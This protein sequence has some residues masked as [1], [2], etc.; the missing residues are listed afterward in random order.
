MLHLN[1]PNRDDGWRTK[2]VRKSKWMLINIFFPEFI[3]AKAV[4]DLRLALDDLRE[5]DDNL[6]NLKT[7][8]NDVNCYTRGT[9]LVHRWTWEVD[10]PSTYLY[11]LFLLPVPENTSNKGESWTSKICH[12]LRNLLPSS[13]KNP[14]QAGANHTLDLAV[15]AEAQILHPNTYYSTTR[16]WTLKHT[17]YAQ[18]GGILHPSKPLFEDDLEAKSRQPSGSDDEP[19]YQIL[20]ATKLTSRCYWEKNQPPP[21]DHLI[22]DKKDI[23]DKSKSDWL[24]I[25]I[26]I[27]Q[28]GWI[29]L[30]VLTRHV[31]GLPITQLEVA[32]VSFAF[33]AILTYIA[34]AGKPKNIS[35]PSIV[36]IFRNIDPDKYE[37][38]SRTKSFAL[39]LQCPVKAAARAKDVSKLPRISNDMVLMEGAVP[40]MVVI[41]VISSLCFGGLHCLAWNFKF[42]SYIELLFWRAACLV[43]AIL[44]TITFGVSLLMINAGATVQVQFLEK[45]NNRFLDKF[46]SKSHD[47]TKEGPFQDWWNLMQQ[48]MRYRSSE[49][50]RELVAAPTGSRNWSKRRSKGPVKK[51]R[52]SKSGQLAFKDCWKLFRELQEFEE[53][54]K[55]AQH[56]IQ[57]SKCGKGPTISTGSA[58]ELSWLWLKSAG[59]LRELAATCPGGVKFWKEHQEFIRESV[60]KDEDQKTETPTLPLDT[61]IEKIGQVYEEVT[62][63]NRPWFRRRKVFMWLSTGFNVCSIAIYTIARS[64]TLILLFTSLRQAPVEIYQITPWLRFLP[65]IG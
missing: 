12:R 33:L 6:R 40:P 8:K 64:I 55:Q 35:E 56:I 1:V 23:N 42:P 61:I 4:C 52:T 41:M 15:D 63:E 26:T 14:V 28:I 20:T 37:L 11:R 44:P 51:N 36:T 43:V 48:D 27:C 34:N 45:F 46:D 38:K 29:I 58:A 62:K 47:K 30:G 13:A 18:M 57:A 25:I 22:L 31:S 53:Y 21:L 39:W 54:W 17:Y 50:I 60:N 16:K 24:L 49:E 19:E 59:S 10:Y 3:F 32:T 9:K 2:A 65:N 5:I 7:C